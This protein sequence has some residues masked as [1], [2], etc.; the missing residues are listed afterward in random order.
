MYVCTY[1]FGMGFQKENKDMPHICKLHEKYSHFGDSKKKR[2]E[3][4]K[5]IWK[6]YTS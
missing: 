6:R 5:S 4:H 2:K 1:V 3:R